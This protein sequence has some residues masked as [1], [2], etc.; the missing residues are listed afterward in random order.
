VIVS[1]PPALLRQ[2]K[3]DGFACVSCAWAKPADPHVFEFCESGA[4]ATTW[5]ITSRRADDGFFASHTL[6]ELET[7]TDHDLEEV[8]R[9]VRPM[10]WEPQTD[11]YVPLECT[12][13]S[14]KPDDTSPPR[15]QSGSFAFLV[16]LAA[17]PIKTLCGWIAACS[18]RQSGSC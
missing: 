17:K 2:N 11:R 10:R 13:P 18:R 15:V 3:P 8:G 7:W 16:R 9:L 4:K 14:S 5:E 1:A 12:R 6:Q